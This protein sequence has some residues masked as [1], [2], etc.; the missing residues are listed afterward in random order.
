MKLVVGLGNPGPRY[1]RS[2]HNVGFRVVEHLARDQGLD[3]DAERFLGRYAEGFLPPAPG[4]DADAERLG[5]LEPATF[6][7]RSGDAVAAAVAELVELDP[8]RDLVVVYDDLDLPLGRLRLRP[9]GGAGGHRGVQ[10]VI[11]ALGTRDFPRLRFGIGRPDPG[12][13]PGEPHAPREP[14]REVVDF[15][16]DA[17]SADEERVLAARVPV[18]A[19]AALVLLRDGAE[20]AMGRFNAAP[21]DPAAP[22]GG[23]SG[24]FRTG[25]PGLTDPGSGRPLGR[26]RPEA[27]VEE[28]TSMSELR[29][30]LSAEAEKLKQQRD[31]LRVQ[32]DLG[33]M[34]VRE[35]WEDIDRKWDHLQ[36]KLKV[37]AGEAREAGGDVGDAAQTLLDEIKSG[38]SRLKKLI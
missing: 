33:K 1:A 37:L 31:E 7:N 14:D 11:D 30:R 13:A 21:L 34:E 35:A 15:V 8:G 10:S 36:G 24:G 19:E 12:A 3:L 2:R 32:L 28:E 29:D 18:A 4:S 9:R 26:A 27:A 5:L 23:G 22:A 16:L 38:F 17:F 20:V 6:M 25:E